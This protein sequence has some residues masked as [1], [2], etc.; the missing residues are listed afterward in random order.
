M[1]A[2][3]I[4]V[5]HVARAVIL[6]LQLQPCLAFCRRT[7]N[8]TKINSHTARLNTRIKPSTRLWFRKNSGRFSA[9]ALP[10]PSGENT[11]QSH[12][13]PIRQDHGPQCQHRIDTPPQALL[14][15]CD[16]QSVPESRPASTLLSAG[17]R[18]ILPLGSLPRRVGPD[19]GPATR[20]RSRS[21]WGGRFHGLG[22]RI[23]LPC[24]CS[25]AVADFSHRLLS[26]WAR[27]SAC[28]V[29]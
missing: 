16:A 7:T 9:K 28:R 18:T 20:R 8:S 15:C 22:G 27:C 23:F 25:L 24:L 17:A 29:A 19:A 14:G 2:R 10:S 13:A 6:Q 26:R 12:T 5:G 21:R 1:P 3:S 4:A 11:V